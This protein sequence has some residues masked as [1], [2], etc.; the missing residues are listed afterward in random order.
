MALGLKHFGLYPTEKADISEKKY[1]TLLQ[2][3]AAKNLGLKENQVVLDAGRGQ[4]FVSNIL[5]K[6]IWTKNFWNNSCPF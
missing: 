2:D 4:G 5:G 1:L 3:L 6:K